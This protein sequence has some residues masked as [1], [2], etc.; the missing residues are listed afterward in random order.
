[1]RLLFRKLKV[2]IRKLRF[3]TPPPP[4]QGPGSVLKEK[5]GSAA[6]ILSLM[7]SA[8]VL[9]T[10]YITQKITSSFLSEQ[11]QE[12][13]DFEKHLVTQSAQALAG[14]LVANNLVMCREDGW[15][16]KQSK[17]RWSTAEDAD[18]ISNFNL[19]HEEDSNEGLSYE[20][21]Y[22][23]EGIEKT[24]TV[25]FTLVDWRDTSIENL[26]GEIPEYICRDAT[27]MSIIKD[28]ECPEYSSLSSSDRT[29]QPCQRG[30]AKVSNTRCEYIRAVDG[31]H[32][33][34][35]VKVEVPFTDTV[36]G[37][38]R[39]HI[40]LSGIRRPLSFVIFQSITSGKKCS[41]SC[42][43]GAVVNFVPDCRSDTVP[44]EDKIYSGLASK[45]TTIKNE[46]PGS[47]YKLSILK[48]TL[49]L[50]D[51]SLALDVTPDIIKGSGK[52]VL[53]PGETLK[54]EHFYECPI[55]VRDE[56]VYRVGE[57]DGVSNTVRNTMT[58]F[59]KVS[60]SLYVD[61]QPLGA[62]Y[63]SSEGAAILSTVSSSES[64]FV[65]SPRESFG[66]AVCEGEPTCNAR[67]ETGICQYVDI[68]PRRLFSSPF[69]S[70]DSTLEQLII[71]KM[72]TITS[73]PPPRFVSGGGDGDGGGN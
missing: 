18:N 3:S 23:I 55:I 73:V 44:S 45:I 32:W 9:G 25:S 37:L 72:I 41:L 51:N 22:S 56:V 66:S 28:A 47:I 7:V 4:H 67:G 8:G 71:T 1:M 2:Y 19:S 36:S 15:T 43:V 31:D 69:S 50:T 16:G 63:S 53:F 12:M 24:Y 27:K 39:K 13:E 62:C 64:V 6:L 54:V 34:V 26:I 35:L 65:I 58:P 33:I 46:G 40:A 57:V 49:D 38:N 17:C 68:E 5:K 20:S 42:N 21:K 10:I 11:S 60:Y 30:G 61:T 70:M 48:T 52:E 59:A 29:N 14:Y